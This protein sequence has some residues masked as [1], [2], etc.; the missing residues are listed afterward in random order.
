M[1]RSRGGFAAKSDG[2]R[3]AFL[4]WNPRKHGFGVVGNHSGL[5]GKL[6]KFAC[7]CLL[8]NCHGKR[9]WMVLEESL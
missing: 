5:V 3:R 1:S 7:F 4:V 8:A 6:C 2:D 9:C